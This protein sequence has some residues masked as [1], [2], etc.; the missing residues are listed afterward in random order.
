MGNVAVAVIVVQPARNA[1]VLER[2]DA[3]H[4]IVPGS[5]KI[6]PVNPADPGYP[7]KNIT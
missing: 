5:S 4:D 2:G 3:V 6:Y 1:V 7:V